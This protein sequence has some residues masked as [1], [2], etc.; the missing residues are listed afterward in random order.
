[1]LIN[2]FYT[3]TPPPTH[4]LKITCLSVLCQLKSLPHLNSLSHYRKDL[5]SSLDVW[6]KD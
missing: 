4:T 5:Y 2:T 6:I 3:D 1:M